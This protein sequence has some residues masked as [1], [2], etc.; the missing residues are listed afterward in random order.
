M[1]PEAASTIRNSRP[2]DAPAVF[3][4]CKAVAA[5][6]GGLAHAPDEIRAYGRGLKA[7]AHTLGDLTVA[8]HPQPH[9]RGTGRALFMR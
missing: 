6:P 9:A 3:D 1:A 2:A 5:P 7:F 4:P 8:V